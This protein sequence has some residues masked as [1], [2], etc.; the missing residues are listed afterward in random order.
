MSQGGRRHFLYNF[1]IEHAL[2]VM[3]A[4]KRVINCCAVIGRDEHVHAKVD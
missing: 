1:V 2:A 4:Q 3:T